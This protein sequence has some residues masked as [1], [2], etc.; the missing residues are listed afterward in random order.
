MVLCSRS[1]AEPVFKAL[2]TAFAHY[3]QA[4]NSVLIPESSMQYPFS[5]IRSSMRCQLRSYHYSYHYIQPVPLLRTRMSKIYNYN[6]VVLFVVALSSG[7]CCLARQWVRHSPLGWIGF[8]RT[9]AS[10]SGLKWSVVVCSGP[11]WTAFSAEWPAVCTV[12]KWL[13]FTTVRVSG[14]WL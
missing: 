4:V 2:N 1:N 7:L 11:K 6:S 12:K 8:R 10:R 5:I 9:T 3:S 14:A 13:V